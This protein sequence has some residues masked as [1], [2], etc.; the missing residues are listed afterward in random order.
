[1]VKTNQY[2]NPKS[3]WQKMIGPLI[4]KYDSET[5]K[6]FKAHKDEIKRR[7]IKSVSENNKLWNTKYKPKLN[8]IEKKHDIAY[9]KIWSKY[10]KML[11]NKGKK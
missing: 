8:I 11:K 7:K 2:I 3:T 5:K 6:I 4:K 9:K 10:H 1:M